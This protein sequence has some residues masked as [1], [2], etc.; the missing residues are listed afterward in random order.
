MEDTQLHWNP[1]KVLKQ[2]EFYF[3]DSNYPKDRY[4]RAQAA[5]DEQGFVSLEKIAAFSRMKQ[6]GATDVKKIAEVLRKSELLVVNE[7]GTMVKRKTPVPVFDKAYS[8]RILFMKGWPLTITIEDI[9]EAITS[10][11][12]GKV[13]SVRIRKNPDKTPKNS[14]LVEFETEDQA[15][16]LLA[17]GTFK[18]KDTD[19]S[20]MKTKTEWLEERKKKK[21]EQKNEGKA[22]GNESKKRKKESTEEGE[23]EEEEEEEEKKK[24][25]KEEEEEEKKE[26]K[27]EGEKSKKKDGSIIH[28]KNVISDQITREIIKGFFETHGPVKYVDFRKGDV[29]GYVRMTTED[30]KKAVEEIQTKKLELQGRLLEL[31]ILEGEE[32]KAYW[33][34]ANGQKKNYRKPKSK[35]KRF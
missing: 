11:G 34:K 22:N 14:A 4:L 30:A 3:S 18:Y 24:G 19:I 17:E 15:K 31:K 1:Q 13:L 28:F 23:D 20:S 9:E 33:Q 32:E 7:E 16:A 10:A 21:K 26:K 8:N 12:K 25:T 27:E 35:K 5:L 2:V 6:I 29:S